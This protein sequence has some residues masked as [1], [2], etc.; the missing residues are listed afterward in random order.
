MFFW[1]SFAIV[2]TL[3]PL[4]IFKIASKY[5]EKKILLK[6]ETD[7]VK[8][9]FTLSF[10]LTIGVF[11]LWYLLSVVCK[12][13][14][15]S[16]FFLFSLLLLQNIF[17]YAYY[18]YYLGHLSPKNP[19]KTQYHDPRALFE[20]AITTLL[21]L[22][23]SISVFVTCAVLFSILF[24][25]IKFFDFVPLKDFLLSTHWGPQEFSSPPLP[26]QLASFSILPLLSGS[27]LITLIALLIA[28]PIGLMTAI[29]LSE[30]A[31]PNLRQL[32]KPVLE[33]LA[34]IPTIVYGFFAALIVGP[35]LHKIGAKFGIMIVT[36]SALSVGIVM[37][38][39]IVPFIASLSDDVL[40]ALPLSIR[41]ASI[42]MGATQAETI[43]KVVIP[44]AL[45]G[46]ASAFLLAI[47]RA[48]GETML[49]VM[50]AG[51]SAQM[52]FNPLSSVTTVTVQIV[53]LLTGDQTFDNP[54]TL[55][56]FALGLALFI[57][58]LVLNLFAFNIIKRYSYKL[59]F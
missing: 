33:I 53:S 47:S 46:I 54:K 26:E 36:E 48:I 32:F 17:C 25:A 10:L 52:T 55:A 45:P 42:G 11:L 27:V 34:G 49:V 56:A 19:F 20:E 35:A 5:R 43:Q 21:L 29:Y 50:A 31:S 58:T 14:T 57:I 24:E 40:Q 4:S 8:Y 39:M 2:W 37:G 12:F 13:F 9:I 7:Y 16:P 23:S 18:A 28:G 30:Y 41:Q 15:I 44:A 51:L 3:G 59:S 38:M 22:A 1:I 6:K